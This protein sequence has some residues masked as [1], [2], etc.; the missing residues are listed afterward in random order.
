MQGKGSAP[1]QVT[2]PLPPGAWRVAQALILSEANMMFD[3]Y[4]EYMR[5]QAEGPEF[6][7]GP[8]PGELVCVLPG[9]PSRLGWPRVL[10]LHL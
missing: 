1:L 10:Y 3:Q 5:T 4:L 2:V 6:Q 8:C 9:P 7:V